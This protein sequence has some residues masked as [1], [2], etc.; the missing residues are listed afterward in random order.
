MSG[1]ATAA[2][3]LEVLTLGLR[4]EIFAVEARQVREILDVPPITEMPGAPAFLNGLINVRGKVVPLGDLRLKLG[5]QPQPPTIDTRVVVVEIDIGGEPTIV[6]LRA[7]KVYEMAE[8]AADSL[9][10]APRIGMRWR[11]D[12]VRCIGKR[13]ND[14]LIVLDLQAMFVGPT[15][16]AAA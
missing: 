4:G 9:A 8:M 10:E 2:P 11:P 12:F 16:D 6:G 3:G 14:F 1:R 5:M 7:D 15:P 13:G